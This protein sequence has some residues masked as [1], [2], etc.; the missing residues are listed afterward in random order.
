MH[1]RDWGMLHWCKHELFE[2]LK[3]KSHGCHEH[4][5]HGHHGAHESVECCHSEIVV[6]ALPGERRIV[7]FLVKNDTQCPVT[8]TPH[9][10]PF[11]ECGCEDQP[12]DNAPT[13]ILVPPDPATIGPC[14]SHG[15][16]IIID[17]GGLKPCHCYCTTLNLDGTCCDPV[18]VVLCLGG[19]VPAVCHHDTSKL[20]AFVRAC[21]FH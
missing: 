21:C 18:R 16:D 13:P 15:F 10:R 11:S 6:H 5:H 9:I 14:G 4:W 20:R 2:K 17:T 7:P 8:V 12:I 1:G 3:K 19:K